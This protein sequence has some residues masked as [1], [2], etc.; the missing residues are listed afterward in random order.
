MVIV[1][2]VDMYIVI[3]ITITVLIDTTEQPDSA[4]YYIFVL[5]NRWYRLFH[6]DLYHV[7]PMCHTITDYYWPRFAVVISYLAVTISNGDDNDEW[8]Q[9]EL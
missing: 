5:P 4:L 7:V 8:W 2:D 6:R 3:A 1:S 9:S